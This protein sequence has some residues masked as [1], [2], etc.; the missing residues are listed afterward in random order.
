MLRTVLDSNLS[1]SISDAQ[2]PDRPLIWVNAAFTRLT[3]YP[4]DEAVGRNC[5]F[6][7]GAGTDPRTVARIRT[8]LDAGRTIATVVRN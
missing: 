3:G 8:E 6:L 4:L 2:R 5:R 7:Q 1:I